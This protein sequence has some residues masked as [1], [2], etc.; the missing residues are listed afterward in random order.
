MPE[1]TSP[2]HIS[3]TVYSCNLQKWVIGTNFELN[4]KVPAENQKKKSSYTVI[5]FSNICIFSKPNP[6][7]MLNFFTRHS[8]CYPLKGYKESSASLF[9]EE[10]NQPGSRYSSC[11]SQKQPPNWELGGLNRKPARL[12]PC[13][14]A[15][16]FGRKNNS[17]VTLSAT[18]RE[19]PLHCFKTHR[20]SY[21]LCAQTHLQCRPSSSPHPF[22]LFFQSW[23]PTLSSPSLS[24][25]D[26][27]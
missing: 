12:F 27:P 26:S 3:P 15:W 4:H 23:W 17:H 11:L 13:S 16:L 18:F 24:A 6:S 22:F 2:G 20:L 5:F 25:A 14:S 9:A 21:C 1:H 19:L 8:K 10:N 7:L